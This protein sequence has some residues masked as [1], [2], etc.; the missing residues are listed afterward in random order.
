MTANKKETNNARNQAMVQLKSIIGM[1]KALERAEKSGNG[2][3]A[4]TAIND[5]PLSVEV[6]S[7]WG[8]PG[9]VREA[10][11]FRILLCTG[12][13]ACQIIGELDENKEPYKA[14]IQYQDWFTPWTDL[15]LSDNQEEFVLTY[16]RQFFY[17]E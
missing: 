2:D 3:N 5:D 13:P 10:V 15:N 14:R 17:G 6:R 1:V 11:D 12:G 4:R 9:T 16:C 8:S 7:D